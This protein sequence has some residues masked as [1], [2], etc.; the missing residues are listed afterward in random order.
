[1]EFFIIEAHFGKI[2]CSE[3]WVSRGKQTQQKSDDLSEASIP[4]LSIGKEST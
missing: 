4:G 3:K 1:M 2:I